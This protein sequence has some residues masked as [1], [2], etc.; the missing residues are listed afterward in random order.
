MKIPKRIK[1]YNFMKP[2][3]ESM[4]F[5]YEDFIESVRITELHNN[6]LRKCCLNNHINWYF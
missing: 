5:N 3:I 1:H 6:F 2:I 4:G